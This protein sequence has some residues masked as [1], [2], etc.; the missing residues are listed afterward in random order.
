MLQGA[1]DGRSILGGSRVRQ[2]CAIIT[3]RTFR[4]IKDRVYL[5]FF[6][7][8]FKFRNFSKKSILLAFGK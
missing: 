6:I 8:I 5:L 4:I 7:D 3:C 2:C 1:M